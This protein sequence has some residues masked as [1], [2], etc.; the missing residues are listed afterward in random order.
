MGSQGYGQGAIGGSQA[1]KPVGVI[2]R[3][4][5]YGS[6]FLSI[7]SYGQAQVGTE[8][9]LHMAN[10]VGGGTWGLATGAGGGKPWLEASTAPLNQRLR[11]NRDGVYLY[12][13]GIG[14]QISDQSAFPTNTNFLLKT[15]ISND[16]IT[17]SQVASDSKFFVTSWNATFASLFTMV[18]I[19]FGKDTFVKSDVTVSQIVLPVGEHIVANPLNLGLNF[20]NCAYVGERF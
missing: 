6:Y 13:C 20:V 9:P 17:Y 16:D 19:P 8:A 5:G 1:S 18:M 2:S 14:L 15:Y 4:S 10:T 3:V 7:G 11:F 12:R